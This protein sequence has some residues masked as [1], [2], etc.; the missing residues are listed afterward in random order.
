MAAASAGA[1][2]VASS[3][4]TKLSE[5]DKRSVGNLINKIKSSGNKITLELLREFKTLDASK[6]RPTHCYEDAMTR[7]PIIKE[8]ESKPQFGRYNKPPGQGGRGGHGGGGGNKYPH[9][10]REHNG[11]DFKTGQFKPPQQREREEPMDPF[12]R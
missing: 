11:G 7:T 4:M 2:N 12:K 6:Q 10:Q 8:L 1:I 5:A 9:K 3:A